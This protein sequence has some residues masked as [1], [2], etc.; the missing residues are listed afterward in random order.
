[1]G[2]EALCSL[3]GW[4]ALKICLS[5]DKAAEPRQDS[6]VRALGWQPWRARVGGTSEARGGATRHPGALSEPPLASGRKEER[7]PS[8]PGQIT[9]LGCS[10]FPGRRSSRGLSRTPPAGGRCPGR[11]GGVGGG[12]RQG[13]GGRASWG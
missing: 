2:V 4:W 3:P 11:R 12:R 8:P 9:D 5:P 1:M 7:I 6:E 13:R 10:S